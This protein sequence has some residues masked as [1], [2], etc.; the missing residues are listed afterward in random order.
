MFRHFF[1]QIHFFSSFLSQRSDL[2]FENFILYYIVVLILEAY[3]GPYQTSKMEFFA[4]SV[5]GLKPQKT[6]S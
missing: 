2:P 3:S 5:N 1:H 6:P 4:K